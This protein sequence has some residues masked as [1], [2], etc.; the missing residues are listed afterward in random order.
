MR[1]VVE[2]FVK[3]PFYANIIIVFVLVAGLFSFFNMKKSFFPE[4]K[5]RHISVSVFYP[6]A[7]PKEMDEGVTTR[8]EQAVKGIVGIKE[9]KATSSENF[10]SVSIE[11]TG[12]YDLDETL[13]EVKN[14]VDGIS[15]LPSAAERPLVFKRRS[16]TGA[17]NLSISGSA[18]LEQLKQYAYD[19]EDD[20]FASG[21]ISQVN[22]SGF[23]SLEI[24]V[25]VTEENLLRHT[26]TFDEISRA[27]A[28]N[29]TDISAGMI[30]SGKEEILIRSRSRSVKPEDIGKIIIRANTSGGFL[31]IRDIAKV[32]TKFADVSSF[33]HKNGQEAVRITVNKLP[34]EDLQKISNFVKSYAKKF[35]DNHTDAQIATDFDFLTMLNSRLDLL[36]N[37]GGFGLL[38]VVLSLALFLNIRLSGWVAWGIP[39]AFL[40]MFIIGVNFDVTLN[41]ISLFGMILVIGILVDDGIVIAENIFSHFEQGKSPER[42]AIDGTME[43]LPS[44][45]TSVLTTVVAFVP[46][47]LIKTGG[48]EFLYEMAFVVIFSLLFSLSEAFFVLPA[49]LGNKHVL[50]RNKNGENKFRKKLNQGIAFMRER[51]Y[52]VFLKFAIKWRWIFVFIPLTLMIITAG[53]FQGG[54]IKA[55]FFP[56]MEMDFFSVDFAFKPGD[57]KDKTEEYIKKFSKAV[58]EVNEDLKIEYSDTSDFVSYTYEILGSS[59][60]GQESGAHAGS[61]MVGLRD[62]EGAPLSSADVRELVEKKIGKQPEVS[63]IKVGAMSHR[64]GAPVSVM[65]QGKNN[66]EL[67]EAKLFLQ[68]KLKTLPKLN[69]ITDD[70]ASGK[71]EVLIEMKPKA[72]FLGLDK[73]YIANQVR[74]G[75]YGGQSQRL[76]SG[77][78]ELRVWVRYP[79]SDRKTLGQFE[80]MKI[81]TPA[82]DFPVSELIDYEIERGPVNIRRYNSIR[83]ITVEAGLVK[84]K[85]PVPPILAHIEKEFIPEL[86]SKYPGVT[87]EFQGQ[88]KRSKETG[89][90]MMKYF[91]GAFLVILLILMLHFKSAAQAILVLMMIPL[92]WLGALW[93]H[94]FEN[95]VVSMLSAWGMVALS[96]VIVNDAVVFMAKYN[97]LLIKGEDIE[98][99]V[100]KAGLSRFRPIVLTTITTVL[101]LY[102][103]IWEKSFQAQLI[104]PMAIALA[105]GVLVGTAFILT[106]FPVL[107]LCWS[108]LKVV[109]YRLWTGK[110]KT[111]EELEVAVQNT[112]RSI[113]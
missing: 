113:D 70:N 110:T 103:L 60:N 66:E 31:R 4:T 43:V 12:E 9:T 81:K 6:G 14:A 2:T 94:G 19:I 44:V 48:M 16:M 62:M 21:E 93:G 87:V 34:E 32:K 75:F 79:K 106:F 10:T 61:I 18:G 98:T 85:D 5:S 67:I 7:S 59:Y 80:T 72:Y 83:Q 46:L 64:W 57:G 76:Q 45:I 33:A 86:K 30:K 24:S 84:A 108:D 51:I 112:N 74:Q 3:Y 22:V 11:T 27:I 78:D 100:F 63:K 105:Y 68:E 40:G 77:K 1:K 26:I 15:S 55:T 54:I 69:N 35:N 38:L 95:M 42:A 25:E 107:I 36:Y 8:I 37:N 52:G 88:A 109:I 28:L 50:K 96:G 49:H 65:L 111:R 89:S 99:S 71:Q 101:G 39:S 53:L 56:Q 97:G 102:P 13:A 82:G 58:W 90:E 47:M 17:M 104:I 73:N 23:P 91:A 41:M 29:N 20:F 92:G